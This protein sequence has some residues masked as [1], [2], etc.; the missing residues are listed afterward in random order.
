MRHW[1]RVTCLSTAFCTL[2]SL[3]LL[4]FPASPGHTPQCSPI[5]Y[6]NI[7]FFHLKLC[8]LSFSSARRWWICVSDNLCVLP[9]GF[10]PSNQRCYNQ[11]N[12]YPFSIY[13]EIRTFHVLWKDI[14]QVWKLCKKKLENEFRSKLFSIKLLTPIQHKDTK[15]IIH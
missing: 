14:L 15:R 5:W 6:I 3:S 8:F 2:T 11:G 12:S 4:V 10:S 1:W 9:D 13:V 7:V